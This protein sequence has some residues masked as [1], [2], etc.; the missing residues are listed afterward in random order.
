MYKLTIKYCAVDMEHIDKS[1][2]FFKTIEEAKNRAC[3]IAKTDLF[4]EDDDHYTISYDM[5]N[6]IEFF[7]E[8]YF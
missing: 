7:I 8:F 6:E 5:E 2:E 4:W 1:S 3:E